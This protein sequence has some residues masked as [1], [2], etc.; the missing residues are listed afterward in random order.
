MIL[1]LVGKNFC[2]LS[3]TDFSCSP[4]EFQCDN[5][6]CT[7]STH[8]CDNDINCIDGS[9]EKDCTCLKV[10]LPCSSGG[11]VPSDKLCNGLDDCSDGTDERFCGKSTMKSWIYLAIICHSCTFMV[12]KLHIL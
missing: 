9:D 12:L 7:S 2:S 8:R 3:L 11:C 4:N 5:G 1:K 10:E 6:Q